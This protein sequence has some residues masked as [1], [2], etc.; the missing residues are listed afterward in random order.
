M[1]FWFFLVREKA[2]QSVTSIPAKAIDLD[3]RIG[4]ARPG[5]DA[6]LVVWDT[7]PLR[8]GATPLQV[9]IDGVSQLNTAEVE[10]SMGANF[11]E[12]VN[13]A[14]VA[15]AAVVE[16]PKMRAKIEESERQAVCSMA[17][18]AGSSFIITGI[19]K[20]FMDNWPKS[21]TE[22]AEGG[23]GNLTLVVSDGSI[24]CF[25]PSC[26][27]A[28][29][30]LQPTESPPVRLSLSNGHLTP[31]LTALTSSLGMIEISTDPSTGDGIVDPLLD[32]RD[33]SN[34]PL[35]KFGVELRGKAFARARMGGVTRAVSPPTALA[36]GFAVGVSV[37]IL[38]GEG[39][40][41][42]DGGVFREEVALHLRIDG[43]AK[44]GPYR[45]ISKA[46][47][48]LREIV[49]SGKGKYNET[50]YGR[51]AAGNLPLIVVAN[52]QVCGCLGSGWM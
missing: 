25:A 39:R 49:A 43:R 5:Y 26:E 48:L 16:E 23:H 33:P 3:Y 17:R 34:L 42:L 1:G 10:K 11:A 38:T 8:I 37:G 29:A 14:A 6:D 36:G 31:G 47:K 19:K 2:L 27:S 41:L 44:V 12:P 51:V 30:D 20:S 18:A 15:V 21:I 24:S 13:E 7:H 50:L 22:S 4:Y 32:A 28:I 35:A 46:V 45:S 9:F 40:D 52:N